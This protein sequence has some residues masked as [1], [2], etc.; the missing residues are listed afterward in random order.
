MHQL[1]YISTARYRVSERELQN[2]LAI[3]RD[4]NRKCGVSGL[5]VSGGQRFLQALEGPS[6]SVSETYE[7]IM[8]DPRHFA[9]V[10]LGSRTVE[11]RAFGEWSMAYETGVCTSGPSVVEAVFQLTDAMTDKGLQ[12]EFRTFAELHAKAA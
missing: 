7:R 2:I 6:A 8:S 4:N 11:S 10:V 3:S 12:A 9:C 5:L 1:V